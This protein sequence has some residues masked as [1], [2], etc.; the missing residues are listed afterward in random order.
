MGKASGGD[1]TPLPL[2]GDAVEIVAKRNRSNLQRYKTQ[3]LPSFFVF[4]TL[5]EREGICVI[6]AG[7]SAN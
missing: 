2:K 5:R 6:V 3:S 4:Y 1:V 7:L